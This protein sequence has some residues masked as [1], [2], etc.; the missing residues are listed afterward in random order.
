M[1]RGRS[2]PRARP[3]P[4][5]APGSRM[6]FLA[7]V[8]ASSWSRPSGARAHGGEGRR[9]TARADEWNIS[10]TTGTPIRSARRGPHR[11]EARSSFSRSTASVHSLSR[12]KPA[13]TLDRSDVDDD[14]VPG[15]DAERVE[16][17]VLVLEAR[18]PRPRRPPASSTRAPCTAPD[19]SKGGARDRWKQAGDLLE[20]HSVLFPPCELVHRMRAER[21]EIRGNAEDLDSVLLVP[22]QDR[23]QRVEVVRDQLAQAV[24]CRVGRGAR[25][26]RKMA[27][28]C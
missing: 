1:H 11:D 2:S 17:P 14:L 13:A 6:D 5:P 15:V 28:R 23:L 25:C 16:E 9:G 21:D 19:G 8:D 10:S 7:A 12:P 20:A 3:A 18:R 26:A 4:Y 27:A 22:A 24:R